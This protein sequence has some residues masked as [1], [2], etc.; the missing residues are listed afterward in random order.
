MGLNKSYI[1]HQNGLS[2]LVDYATTRL[3]DNVPA[4]GAECSF[5]ECAL[6]VVMLKED[7][8]PRN[9]VLVDGNGRQVNNILRIAL[10]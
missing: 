3:I 5:P 2:C 6:T 8:R 7:M 10:Y 9:V 4:L 1:K